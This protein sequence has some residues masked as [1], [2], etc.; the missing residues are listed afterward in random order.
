VCSLTDHG[1][2]FGAT[3]GGLGLTGLLTWVEVQLRRTP[4]PC[5]DA[6]TIRFGD[7]AEFFALSRES[8]RD[9]EYT[10]AWV[11]GAASGRGL[12]RGLFIRANHA[13]GPAEPRSG[14]RRPVTVPPIPLCT[15]LAVTLFN[16]LYYHGHGA[17]RRAHQHYEDFFFPLDRIANWNT[18]YGRR[19]FY[20]YQCVVPAAGGDAVVRALL[21]TIAAS[22]LAS[23]LAVLKVFGARPS[24]G[25]LSFPM[26]GITL[27]LDFPNRG[28]RT[29]A[30]FE[31]LDALV[32]D[33]GGRLYPAKDARMSGELFRASYPAWRELQAYVDPHVSSTFWRRVAADAEDR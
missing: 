2:W 10:V 9:Y 3:I 32:R 24:P 19:G 4:N 31:R 23:S 18:L 13:G 6:E 29:L 33:A 15:T 21:G 22:G 17:R 27:A 25:L 1:D 7:L 20:Q 8:D 28:P 26:P 16:S 11:D 5:V 14:C 12:G 30:L